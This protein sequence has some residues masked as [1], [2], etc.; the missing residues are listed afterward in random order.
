MSLTEKRELL[1]RSIW[2]KKEAKEYSGLS[3]YYL[4][5]IYKTCQHSKFKNA[6]YRDKFLKEIGTTLEKEICQIE[7]EKV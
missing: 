6:V 4:T 2:K 1:T 7:R 5:K 3:D